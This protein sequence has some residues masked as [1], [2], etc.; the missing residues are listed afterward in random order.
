MW[1]RPLPFFS[2]PATVS[3]FSAVFFQ[4]LLCLE[5][6]NRLSPGRCVYK[7]NAFERE[8]REWE[9]QIRDINRFEYL[10]PDYYFDVSLQDPPTFCLLLFETKKSERNIK[11][12]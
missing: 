12:N 10:S 11:L 7:V 5:D 9:K 8:T 1:K 2:L 4:V 3:A 6:P